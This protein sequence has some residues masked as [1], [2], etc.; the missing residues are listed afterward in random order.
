MSL[1]RT[2]RAHPV[3]KNRLSRSST[4]PTWEVFFCLL[5]GAHFSGHCHPVRPAPWTLL[6]AVR[7][8]RK[9]PRLVAASPNDDRDASGPKVSE[10][11]SGMGVEVTA[12]LVDPAMR[13][14][15]EWTTQGG[16]R[17]NLA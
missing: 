6:A 8:L 14:D 17:F 16:Q 11:S 9:T 12:H 7:P 13:I 1:F 2:S 10:G 5:P 15:Q 3:T 4:F